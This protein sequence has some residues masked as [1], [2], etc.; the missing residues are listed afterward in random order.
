MI[1]KE[2]EILE[3]R[4]GRTTRQVD[5]AIQDIFEGHIF[6]AKDHHPHPDSNKRLFHLVVSRLSREHGHVLGYLKIDAD[7]LQVSING[8]LKNNPITRTI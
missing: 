8:I 1:E 7:N 5:Q 4:T 3:R 6:T 2:A